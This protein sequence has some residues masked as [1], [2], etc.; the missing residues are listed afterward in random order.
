MH[1]H[2]ARLRFG[3]N[4]TVAA[5]PELLL[6]PRPAI[7]AAW[8]I[9]ATLV[10]SIIDVS[11]KALQDGF[12]TPQIVLLRLLCSLPF[13][14]LFAQLGGG[15]GSIRPKRPAWHVLRSFAAAGATF[16]FFYALGE[17]PLMLCVTIGFAAPLIIAL[18]SRPFLG[19]VVGARRWLGIIVGFVGVLL[20]LQPGTAV[21]H[22]AMLA[23]LASTVCWAVLALSARRI[24]GDEPTGAM[25]VFTIPVSLIVALTMTLGD[26]VAPTATQW[27]LFALAGFCG[28][29]VHYCVVYAY[30][31]TRAAVVAPMEYTALLWAALLGFLFWGEV[32][33]GWTVVGAAVIILGGLIVLRENR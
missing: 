5:R 12:D 20:A 11:V 19:E 14:V 10:G 16:G 7:G 17:L 18:L 25:V 2:N 27:A 21:W 4:T 33:T 6:H 26:W 9:L 29:T 15:L 8:M 31:A 3:R 24:G 30:R 1:G 22:P 13:V 23:V 32:P 28:A